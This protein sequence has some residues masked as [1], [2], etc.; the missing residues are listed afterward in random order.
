MRRWQS[1]RHLSFTSNNV[2]LG[3]DGCGYIR[4]EAACNNLSA[5]VVAQQY[6]MQLQSLVYSQVHRL[7]ELPTDAVYLQRLL[8]LRITHCYQFALV[9]DWV[10]RLSRLQ[11]LELNHTLSMTTL[12]ESICKLREL[13]VLRLRSMSLSVLPMIGQLT[14][15][16]VLDVSG[17]A[18]LTSLQDGLSQLV[19]L[20]HLNIT[21][22]YGIPKLPDWISSLQNLLELRMS[23]CR[24]GALPCA[25]GKLAVL[26]CL[27]VGSGALLEL[28]L[29]LSQLQRLLTL[30]IDVCDRLLVLPAKLAALGRLKHLSIFNC[31]AL[32]KLPEEWG[33]ALT[34][35]EDLHLCCCRGLLE[36][37]A[38]ISG[39]T[40]LTSL[41]LSCCHSLTGLPEAMTGM[42]WLAGLNVI[43]C[44]SLVE[45]HWLSTHPAII[46]RSW[47][48]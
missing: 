21:R 10:S 4:C 47:E 23:Y 16:M 41:D 7:K 6:P 24:Y 20:Q 35:L 18:V 14:N 13:R 27:H 46:L 37:P 48:L 12:P 40:R 15:L 3:V 36:L 31:N 42:T 26:E 44:K 29:A 34:A 1:A 28:P 19:G 25:I 5:S 32:V 2:R 30:S 22:C 45:P 43:D 9:Q 11:E 33:I 39:L 38:S 17:C 8:V